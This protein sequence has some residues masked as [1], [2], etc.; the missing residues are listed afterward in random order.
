VHRKT[1]PLLATVAIAASGVVLAMQPVQAGTTTARSAATPTRYA[2]QASGYG[3]RVQGGSVPASSDRSAFQIIACTNLAGLSRDN[4]EATLRPST[5]LTL[6]AA[7]TQVW[8]TSKGGIVSSWARHSIA[9]VKLHNADPAS[10]IVLTGVASTARTWHSASGFHANT[11]TRIA[12]ITVGGNP[13]PLPTSSRSVSV[14]GVATIALGR[15]T[16]TEAAHSATA[17]VD[18]IRLY[19]VAS[20]TSTYLAHSRSEIQ[21]GVRSGIFNGSAYATRAN[22]LSGA[23]TSGPTPLLLMPCQ[24]TAG[25]TQT[26]SLAHAQ[27]GTG[28]VAKSLSTSQRASV[29][30]GVAD[31]YERAAVVG[32]SLPGRLRVSGAVAK[33]HVV[34]TSHGYTMDAKSTGEIFYRGRHL[35][36]PATGALRIPGVAKIESDIVTRTHRGIDVTA[37]RVTLL[38]G[39]GHAVVDIGHAKVSIAPSGL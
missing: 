29:K 33:G 4:S 18:A 27:L 38:G 31:A 28:A 13:A 24:G 32:V 22:G 10:D 14:P 7:K 2:L 21:D 26:R 3:S 15:S 20:H 17:A 35:K 9:S 19:V 23:A 36:I 16:T 5:D 39:G 12:G 25:K 37:L 34:M 30:G 6:S 11:T 1:V 8:T